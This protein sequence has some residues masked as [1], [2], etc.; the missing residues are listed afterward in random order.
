MKIVVIGGSGLIGSQVVSV[1][2]EQGHEV[3]AASLSSG[4][5]ILTGEGLSEVFSGADVVVDVSNSPSFED[6]AVMNFFETAGHNLQ[7]AEK[8]HGV[9]HHVALSVVGTDRLQESGYF[10]AKLV[11]E[12]MISKAGIP[13]SIVRATQF[14]E[15]IE[16]IAGSGKKG[17]E[18][19][20]PAAAIQPIASKDVAAFVAAA[21]LQ[22]PTNAINDVAGP[23]RFPMD[24]LIRRYLHYKNDSTRVVTDVKATYF[25]TAVDDSSLVPLGEAKLGSV[26]LEEWMKLK[27]AVV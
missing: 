26:H 16:A 1:L 20:M 21:A 13:Y 25:G 17:D 18:I 22:A 14:F 11:Q 7:A 3:I 24:D 4:V 12:N 15:F 8:E 23:E 9:K 2:Q 27:A 5:N 19:Y 10:R 6:K